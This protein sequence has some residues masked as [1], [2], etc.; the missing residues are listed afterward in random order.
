MKRRTTMT[1]VPYL[2]SSL[3][4]AACGVAD[5]PGGMPQDPEGSLDQPLYGL[6]TIAATLP[7]GAVLAGPAAPAQAAT[8][9]SFYATPQLVYDLGSSYRI[10]N[11]SSNNSAFQRES[12][13]V[14]SDVSLSNV[15][16]RV[17]TGDFDNNGNPD[18]VMA[19]QRSDGKFDF[20]VSLNGNAPVTW[21]TSGSFSLSK[22]GDRLVVGD[23]N[24]DGRDEPALVYDNGDGT[25]TIY[26]WLST[27]SSFSRTTDYHSG[28]FH[29]SS[30]GNRVA[31]G[32]VDKDGKD[33]IVMAY[34]RS[35][36]TF[37]YNVF[38]GGGSSA[39]V[40]YTSGAFS[41]EPVAGR[42][43]VGDFDGD[44]RD[45][46]AMVRDD[47]DQTMTIWR[48][49]ST[50]SSFAR[51]TDYHSGT[52]VVSNVADRV[53]AGDVNFDGKDDIVAAYQRSD[54]KFDFDVFSAGSSFA[55]A[56]YTSGP[57]SL[58]AVG[59]RFVMPAWKKYTTVPARTYAL[60]KPVYFVHGYDLLDSMPTSIDAYWGTLDYNFKYSSTAP[61]GLSSSNIEYFCYYT[62]LTGCT[63]HFGSDETVP[64]KELAADLAWN[65]YAKY[66]VM[67]KA[68]DIVAHSMGGLIARGALTGVYKHDPAFPP[69]LFVEDAVTIDTPNAG[70]PPPQGGGCAILSHFFDNTQC[71]DML[72]GSAY[73][74]W[75][76]SAPTS[77]ILTDW[78]NIGALDDL[79]IPPSTSVP[80]SMLTDHKVI[81]NSGQILPQSEAHMG[82]LSA[83]TP[84]FGYSYR[85][86]DIV[87]DSHY[88]QQPSS[89]V[90]VP[91]G[92]YSP[93]VMVRNAVKYESF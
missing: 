57:F 85:Y 72:A 60:D 93:S 45:E 44:G 66:S 13:F 21:Y 77:A 26:R 29:L 24:G 11:W 20:K 51:A 7:G 73:V 50:G 59:N 76:M 6:G 28:S 5:G 17:A 92:G 62:K 27:G 53:V 10:Y 40:W 4:L 9:A 8:V 89:Y 70:L 42:L 31:A 18:I 15:A 65:I 68:V 41:L 84:V 91:F 46:P 16:G 80:D 32:D 64:L 35:D 63:T 75:L 83:E 3:C 79:F 81:Y 82:V 78:T 19:A 61:T 1:V 14:A 54:G 34:Q 12:D 39:G 58:S 23:F 36:G 74:N 87:S 33:D 37:Q 56:W 25:M 71:H 67:G 38:D 88:C 90:Q 47:G 48:W 22:V 49:T 52:F 2:L 86:C 30:V 69:F 43:V 55:G